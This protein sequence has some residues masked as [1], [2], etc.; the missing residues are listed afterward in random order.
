[1]ANVVSEV[2]SGVGL[3]GR[4]LGLIM[5]RPRLFVLGAIPPLITSFA[6]VAVLVALITQ[7]DDVVAALTPFAN[8]WGQGARD[9]VR[10]VGEIA[11]VAGAVLIMVISFTT[12]TLAIGSPLYDKI[13]EAVE[14]ELGDPPTE[15]EEPV[16]ASVVRTVRQSAALIAV[17]ALGAVILFACGFLPLV[18]QTVVPIASALFGGWMLCIELVGSAFDRRGHHRLLQR[19]VAMARRRPRVLGFA[20]PTFLLLSIPFAGAVVFPVATAAGTILARELLAPDPAPERT[21]QPS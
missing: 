6:F 2:V 3:L 20:V 13:A 5:K 17:S 10:A 15:V 11:V 7:I 18:G 16:A 8:G 19:R 1:M 12:L 21:A 4:G 14:V 9:L